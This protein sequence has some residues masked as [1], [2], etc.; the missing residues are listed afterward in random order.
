MKKQPRCSSKIIAHLLFI[1][2][3][4]C[5]VIPISGC[6]ETTVS[7]EP[8]SDEPSNTVSQEEDICDSETDDTVTNSVPSE[9]VPNN[10]IVDN[11][12][13]NDNINISNKPNSNA[14]LLASHINSI[15]R[16][17]LNKQ[18][19]YEAAVGFIG[20]ENLDIFG[21]KRI[22]NDEVDCSNNLL[23]HKIKKKQ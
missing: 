18:T 17:S 6:S 20:K 21:I 4:A 19:P 5:S 15:P 22:P 23:C 2:L 1:A 12:E 8:T 11:N 14:E 10:D 13:S 16:E 7:A 9:N 3:L